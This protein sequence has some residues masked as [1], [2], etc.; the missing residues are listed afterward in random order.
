MPVDPATSQ[1]QIFIFVVG[2]VIV[3]LLAGVVTWVK[4]KVG[5]QDKIDARTL[6]QSHAMIYMAK[7]NDE[8][9]LRL[10]PEL[11]KPNTAETVESLLK[12]E[13]GNL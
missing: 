3:A 12:D 4:K 7:S 10:H 11:P 8:E 1:G 6:R 2:S 9:T 5:C 13:Y